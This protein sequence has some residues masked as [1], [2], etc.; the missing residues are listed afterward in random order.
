MTD[1][2]A[3]SAQFV[4][5]YY[6]TFDAD[7]NGLA[8]LYRPTSLLTFEGNPSQGAQAIVE[9]L[10]SLPFQKIQHKV[11][12]TDAQPLPDGSIIVLV[13]GA[14]LFDDSEH[15]Q[16]FSQTFLLKPEGGSYFV[17]NDV[18]RLVYLG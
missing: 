5:F 11:A 15:P 16:N 13:T 12:T 2:N 17:A 10:A 9:K 7:R 18:F 8:S 14:L 6:Q 4:P 1:Y 3:V